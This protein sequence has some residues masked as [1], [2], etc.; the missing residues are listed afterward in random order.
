VVQPTTTSVDAPPDAKPTKER[1]TARTLIFK[2]GMSAD[3]LDP[4]FEALM[5]AGLDPATSTGTNPVF[6]QNP[7]TT[8]GTNPVFVQN[9]TTA[10]G[11]NPAIGQNPSTVTGTNPA[12][13]QNPSTVTGTNQPYTANPSVGPNLAA[14]IAAANP[15]G[16]SNTADSAVAR[17]NSN[18]IPA[19]NPTAGGRPI[20]RTMILKSLA[21]PE[22]DEPVEL[23]EEALTDTTSNEPS[24]LNSEGLSASGQT[25]S[26]T[27][28]SAQPKFAK[29]ATAK[30]LT[31]K[32]FTMPTAEENAKPAPLK[33]VR[34]DSS[35]L[36]NMERDAKPLSIAESL[37]A[38]KQASIT[39]AEDKNDRRPLWLKTIAAH[40]LVKSPMFRS[41]VLLIVLSIALLVCS[42]ALIHSLYSD[43]D[44]YR[45]SNVTTTRAQRHFKSTDG[46]K[47][48]ELTDKGPVLISNG[49][50]IHGKIK[51]VNDA[52]LFS[53]AMAPPAKREIWLQK[54][55]AG[56]VDQDGITL[57]GA[58]APELQI[59]KKID[60]Y[61]SLV[62]AKYKETKI[63]PSDVERLERLSP[64]DFHYTN[65]FTGK[66]DQP[67]VQYKR[68]AAADPTW[69]D[70]TRQAHTWQD[71]PPWKPGA[72]H[73]M[74]LDYCRFFIRG[75]DR[76]GRP[77]FGSTPG[78]AD[79]IE[80]KDG[81]NMNPRRVDKVVDDKDKTP[82]TF[83]VARNAALSHEVAVLRQI[84]PLFPVLLVVVA[85]A[86][87]GW[88]LFLRRMKNNKADST[89]NMTKFTMK[90]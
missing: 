56:Y 59:A 40:P 8:T 43:G 79:Y 50:A 60:S 5:P 83:M 13:G 86:V 37:A 46:A 31:F 62:A 7:T 71:E 52:E 84:G 51:A 35:K 24:I 17:H 68:F 15:L 48:L 73:C 72:I 57:Y 53:L 10:T 20:A 70:H 38:V 11:N 2:K 4:T 64:R 81:N 77:L 61:A 89:S 28:A 78:V 33:I 23:F 45:P 80:L 32:A 19:H 1:K 63:Y 42:S 34:Y 16:F 41:A 65:P 27:G 22:D 75:F 54:T 26:P 67:S 49:K 55:D 12:I 6:A 47:S 76:N 21:P 14:A 39:A 87:G 44:D 85:L 25:G 29:R 3:G 18:V 58:G 30:T 82:A 90:E 69:T 9:P 74:C 88:L 36:R 66:S